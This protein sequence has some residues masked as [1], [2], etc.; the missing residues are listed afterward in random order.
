MNNICTFSLKPSALSMRNQSI[1]DLRPL[2]M[3]SE[4]LLPKGSRLLVCFCVFL[5]R[6]WRAHVVMLDNMYNTA[7][8]CVLTH[9][10]DDCTTICRTKTVFC[11]QTDAWGRQPNLLLLWNSHQ[12]S[13]PLA[14]CPYCVHSLITQLHC[15]K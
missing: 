1:T 7:Y 5:F 14:K 10:T 4:R 3:S 12:E 9:T 8:G 11:A 6:F 2:Y 15:S 13:L